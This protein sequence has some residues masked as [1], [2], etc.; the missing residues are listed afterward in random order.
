VKELAIEELN[1]K[2]SQQLSKI[3]AALIK[4]LENKI[5]WN[6]ANIRRKVFSNLKN[7]KK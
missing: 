6:K 4:A 7:T 2:S 3:I 1:K 5:A